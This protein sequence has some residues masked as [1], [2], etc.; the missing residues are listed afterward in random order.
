[1]KPKDI[2]SMKSKGDMEPMVNQR[3]TE[4]EAQQTLHTIHSQRRR[5]AIRVIGVFVVLVWSLAYIHYFPKDLN[6]P[7]WGR[8]DSPP[9]FDGNYPLVNHGLTL[10]PWEGPASVTFR[11]PHITLDIGNGTQADLRSHLLIREGAVT[12][13]QLLV[14]ALVS[15]AEDGNHFSALRLTVPYDHQGAVRFWMDPEQ[16]HASARLD[17]EL[18]LPPNFSGT[19]NVGGSWLYIEGENLSSARF[20]IL[21]LKA[22][23]GDIHLRGLVPVKEFDAATIE[24]GSVRCGTLVSVVDGD[25]LK[26]TVNTG[27]G[28]IALRAVTSQAKMGPRV[29]SDKESDNKPNKFSLKMQSRS[30]A[31]E[32]EV[33]DKHQHPRLD[34][35]GE[36]VK[37]KPVPL[38]ISAESISGYVR[39]QVELGEMQQLSLFGSSDNKDTTVRVSDNYSGKVMITSP[40]KAE[41]VPKEGSR[42][43]MQYTELRAVD[44]RCM[45]YPSGAIVPQLVGDNITLLS[46]SAVA[47]VEFS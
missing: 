27:S 5:T 35:F 7:N 13:A 8:S 22:R 9:L 20:S 33:K 40:I 47:T 30:G 21:A 29:T 10:V 4:Q 36:Q 15:A 31:I 23:R 11:S 42:S 19:V 17:L 34:V 32:F 1:M 2:H 38:F 37:P 41:I 44:K 14:N 24:A 45:K 12:E 43:V 26:A 6:L 3:K 25:D 18:V 16:P 39:G 28:N 46:K